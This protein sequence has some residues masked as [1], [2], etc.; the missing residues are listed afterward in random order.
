[1]RRGENVRGSQINSAWPLHRRQS[2]VPGSQHSFTMDHLKGRC[3]TYPKIG[4]EKKKSVLINVSSYTEIPVQEDCDQCAPTGQ[5]LILYYV[6]FK[7]I[8]Y[9]VCCAVHS[10]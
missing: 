1:M 5:S 4:R 2:A 8:V 9:R 3:F 6:V 10:T 7:M